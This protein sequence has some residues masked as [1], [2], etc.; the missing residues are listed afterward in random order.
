MDLAAQIEVTLSQLTLAEKVSLLSGSSFTSATGVPRLNLPTINLLDSIN[1]IKT[2][3]PF[4]PTPS[5]CFPSTTC[6]GS[7]W[8]SALL[9]RM[10][11]A[12]AAHAKKGSCN[13]ILGP[14]VNIHRD[15]RGGRN[16]ECFS[17]DPLLTG[18]LAASLVKGIQ[19]G[20][21]AACLKHFV[22]NESELKRRFYR[23]N[24]STETKAMREIYLAAFEYVL[25][26]VK[27][28]A[29]MTA[30]NKILDNSSNE[31][32][33]CSESPIISQILRKE[34][35]YTGCV[36]SDWFG[37]RSTLP[38]LQAEL[39]LEMPGPSVFRGEAVMNLIKSGAISDDLI[40]ERV[41]NVLGLIL[42][43]NDHTDEKTEQTEEKENIDGRRLAR[44]VAAEGIVLLKNN[45][46]A[47]PLKHEEMEGEK[48]AVIGPYALKPPS[49]GGG[50][51]AALPEYQHAPLHRLR[52]SFP[53]S[54][55]IEHELGFTT[56][57]S[58]P[59]L[60]TS[61]TRAKNGQEGIDVQYFIHGSETP[62]LE[63]FNPSTKRVH[64]G[65]V[66]QP[67]T[68]S[69]FSHYIL[70]TTL[71]PLTTG[72]HTIAIQATGAFSLY[73]DDQ[74]TLQDEMTPAPTVED[75]LFVP[76]ALER[77]VIIALHAG[78]SYTIRAVI[79]PHTPEHDTGEPL[80][81]AA[82]L[83]YLEEINPSKMRSDAVILSEQCDTTIIFAGRNEEMESEGF[84]LTSIKLPSEQELAIS[85]IAKASKKT[86][87]VLYGGN[88]IDVSPFIDL[89]DAA[90]FAHFPGQE[91]NQALVN[92][93]TGVT[94]PSGRLATS[95]PKRLEDVPSFEHF[96]AKENER[97]EW[98]MEYTEGLRVGYRGKMEGYEPR[99]E[100]GWGLSYT[101]FEYCHLKCVVR[102]RGRVGKVIVDICVENEGELA[103]FDVVMVFVEPVVS[104]LWRP[105]RE[106]K[107]FE[108]V[109]VEA[110]EKRAVRIEI[111]LDTAFRFWD[112]RVRGE[113]CWRVDN[114][115]Y[116][117]HVGNFHKTVLIKEG[118]TWRGI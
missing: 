62:V 79:K 39:D 4:N 10:G 103:G 20:G 98:E 27:P 29:I 92:I 65:H 93:L 95:W 49:N 35:N 86:I 8:N 113:E 102:G 17:E 64:M 51:A 83:C 71:T 106:L 63:T 45:N 80:V 18:M 23:V 59:A 76:L 36:L 111:G 75:F 14:T 94:N 2:L 85:A 52:P 97:G 30:Y 78:Q 46:N 81:H 28:W 67:L 110:R 53:P 42:K 112:D 12:L 13:V 48:I 16:F 61:L 118:F 6:L 105:R 57:Q 77:S 66:P 114:G 33:Y 116:R 25:K 100:L 87:L 58:T 5:L 82:K 72:N 88:P 7:T 50:S 90:V 41:K 47:L 109:W 96:P 60:S 107:G 84:D 31:G 55:N 1:G 38:A 21:V 99:W 104:S 54:T 91:G 44:R 37:T 40:D 9:H 24:T 19:E 70:S 11:S 43:T 56:H 73:V 22:G 115:Q 89:V 34:W 117:I 26:E 68:Q 108:K 15:P 3:N 69:S 101:T 32:K 74:L